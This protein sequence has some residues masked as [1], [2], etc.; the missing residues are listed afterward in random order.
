INRHDSALQEIS[1]RLSRLTHYLSDFNQYEQ[2]LSHSLAGIYSTVI[3]PLGPRIRVTGR[4]EILQNPYIQA[5]IRTLLLAGIRAGILW[6][7]VG[8]SRWQFMLARKKL[9]QASSELLTHIANY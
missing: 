5:K 9:Y 4:M 6:Q 7:Q 8:G 2:Q 1:Q 3:S